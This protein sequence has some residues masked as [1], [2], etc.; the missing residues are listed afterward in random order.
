MVSAS[1]T[2]D[3]CWCPTHISLAFMIS[4]YEIQIQLSHLCLRARFGYTFTRL[5]VPQEY[6]IPLN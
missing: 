4:E 1:Q 5:K 3:T 2:S 6:C